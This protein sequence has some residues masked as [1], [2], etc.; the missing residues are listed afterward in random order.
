MTFASAEDFES[1]WA[2]YITRGALPVR[3]L[4]TLSPLEQLEIYLLAPGLT[5]VA[6][7]VEVVQLTGERALLRLIDPAPPKPGLVARPPRVAAIVEPPPPP[8]AP[9]EATETPAIETRALEAAVEPVAPPAAGSVGGAAPEPPVDEAGAP[10]L[11]AAPVVEAAAVVE[12]APVVEAALVVE[13]APAVEA[14]P[15]VAK[16]A[17]DAAPA[18]E[19]IPALELTPAPARHL[20]PPIE[21]DAG[22]PAAMPADAVSA[23]DVGSPVAGAG[24]VDEPVVQA[25]AIVDGAHDAKP[26]LP[27]AAGQPESPT[28]A[29]SSTQEIEITNLMPAPG[30]VPPPAPAAFFAS[31]LAL[32]IELEPMDRSGEFTTIEPIATSAGAPAGDA[33]PTLAPPQAS[34]TVS[35]AHTERPGEIAAPA[36]AAA[37]ATA[38][39][40]PAPA[41][42]STVMPP[43]FTG[44]TLRFQ[45]SEDLQGARSSLVGSGAV[46]VVIDGKVP[47]AVIEVKLAV[48]ARETRKKVK[49]TLS[50]AA[51]GTAVVQVVE[52]HGFRDL[53][54]ELEADAAMI[55]PASASGTGGV[56]NALEAS[57]AN[58]STTARTAGGPRTFS[59]PRQGHLTNPT[60][61][62]GIL[63]LPLSRSPSDA[64]LAQPSVPLLLRWLRTTRGVLRLEV[65]AADHPLFTAVFVDG[66]E[67]RTPASLQTLG[68]SLAVPKMSYSIVDLGRPPQMSTTGRTLHLIAETVRALC[69]AHSTEDLGRCFPN[70]SGLCARAIQDVA[71]GLGLS[72]QHARFIKND[73]NGSQFLDEI[74]RAAVGARTVWETMYLLEVYHGLGWD[75][76]AADKKDRATT[77]THERS[78]AAPTADQSWAPF[79]GKDHFQVLGLHWSS[80]PAEVQPAYQKLRSEYGPSG[81]RRP[82]DAAT[83]ERI[84]K[85]LEEAHRVL[86]DTNARRAHRREKYNLV[87]AHQAQLLVQK[88]K[89]ALYRKDFVET[90]NILLAAEDISPSEEAKQLLAALKHKPG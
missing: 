7:K 3:S 87:W 60:T 14:P 69:A 63:A 78:Q 32:S 59:L 55:A 62:E 18:L 67:V 27:A 53:V 2:T 68:R 71:A 90:Q 72:P 9:L 41:A 31:D 80:S 10:V 75:E 79:E 52:K 54:E 83:A 12:A 15:A 81:H 46:L 58:D 34:A 84:L 76:P 89:L 19:L 50:G 77:G 5:P 43:W 88:A 39:A 56:P 74:A 40:A 28:P 1:D 22:A 49:V 70:R 20:E 8:A 25:S 35:P 11:E 65:T 21:D 33:T 86:L 82:A 61:P 66:R 37:A 17:P 13:A 26:R 23:N 85:R 44:D 38:P 30:G 4:R 51:P 57:V 48:G 42:A 16:A 29:A 36:A 45:T 64:E 6:L 24:P 47:L 73:V